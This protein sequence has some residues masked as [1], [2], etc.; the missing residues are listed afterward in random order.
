MKMGLQAAT[1]EVQS[2]GRALDSSTVARCPLWLLQRF[3]RA[4]HCQKSLREAIPEKSAQKIFRA[5][6]Q[7]LRAGRPE[8]EQ[9]GERQ[10]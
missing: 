1:G 4:V 3:A 2:L 5:A 7:I 8:T 6:D 10:T 9:A